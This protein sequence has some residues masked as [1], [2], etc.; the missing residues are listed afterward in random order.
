MKEGHLESY[1]YKVHYIHWEGEGPRILLIH[2]MGMD[3]HSMDK[4]AESLKNDHNI[5]SLTI[6]WHGDS[7]SPVAPLPLFGRH[8]LFLRTA[9][10]R[11]VTHGLP[12]RLVG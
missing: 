1:G 9:E 5:L 3:A 2:S 6:L 4:L 7:N 10:D 11:L 8:G 12:G